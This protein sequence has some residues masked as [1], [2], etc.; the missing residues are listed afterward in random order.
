MARKQLNYSLIKGELTR[1]GVQPDEIRESPKGNYLQ[2]A[3]GASRMSLCHLE[4]IGR[5]LR[6]D[7][8]EYTLEAAELAW[9]FSN[10]EMGADLMVEN[11]HYY[12]R[13]SWC[14]ILD[15][16]LSTEQAAVE[17]V[18]KRLPGVRA[19]V[20]CFLK[21]HLN[22][23]SLL[24]KPENYHTAR[25][26]EFLRYS[27]EVLES[28]LSLLKIPV[29][30]FFQAG[31][32]I[33]HSISN[34]GKKGRGCMD[35]FL[36]SATHCVIF[37]NK[38]CGAASDVDQ[39]KKYVRYCADQGCMIENIYIVHAA[40]DLSAVLKGKDGEYNGSDMGHLISVSYV[41]D[42]IPWIQTIRGLMCGSPEALQIY[43][44]YLLELRAISRQY[45]L[46]TILNGLVEK[47]KKV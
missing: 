16:D 25:L 40:R 27:P 21:K 39:L 26:V 30:D 24:Q 32:A 12:G 7:V 47:A 46:T 29:K 5:K 28:F 13:D 35:A 41:E 6:F 42:L 10:S 15:E 4:V 2:I 34:G 43:D 23:F 36:Q 20:G 18:L 8:E 19:F 11:P 38:V 33:Q 3:V 9:A 17:M 31:I 45:E 14:F 1:S 37:E 44:A 22:R